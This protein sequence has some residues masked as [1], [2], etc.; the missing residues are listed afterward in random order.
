MEPKEDFTFVEPFRRVDW[1]AVQ[2]ADLRR[3]EEARTAQK[4]QRLLGKT[5]GS[6]L[7]GALDNEGKLT[8]FKLKQNTV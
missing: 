8:G 5:L 7:Y 4:A 2:G 6:V 1:R 3:L